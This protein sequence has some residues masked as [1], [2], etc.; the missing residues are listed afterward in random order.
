MCS[1]FKSR[2]IQCTPAE[3]LTPIEKEYLDDFVESKVRFTDNRYFVSL[4]WISPIQLGIHSD[5]SLARLHRLICSLC[6]L[7]RF[8][9]YLSAIEKL[10]NQF[11][12]PIPCTPDST[13]VYYLPCHCVIRLDKL[14]T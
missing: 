8:E 14:T 2:P 5:L 1:N 9:Q 11:A 4:P 3:E 12:E 7:G 13:N 10:I 6:R